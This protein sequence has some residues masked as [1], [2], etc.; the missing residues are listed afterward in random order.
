L[1]GRFFWC[2]A[3]ERLDTARRA[4][5][6]AAPPLR[7]FRSGSR[8]AGPQTPAAPDVGAPMSSAAER[9]DVEGFYFALLRFFSGKVRHL[10]LPDKVLSA[11]SLR[12]LWQLPSKVANNELCPTH[13]MRGRTSPAVERVGAAA[14]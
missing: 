10:L 12:R 8:A 13:T 3:E 11:E 2:P 9:V 1:G 5:G 7:V 6:F 4:R 14:R